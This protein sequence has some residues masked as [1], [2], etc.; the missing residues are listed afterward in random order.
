MANKLF[1]AQLSGVF[2]TDPAVALWTYLKNNWDIATGYTSTPDYGLAGGSITKIKFDTKFG[3]MIGYNFVIVENMPVTIKP[4]DLGAGRFRYTDTKRIQIMTEGTSAK[5][6]KW[7]MER[8]IDS[9]I[10]GNVTGMQ[11]TYGIDEILLSEFVEI[12]VDVTEAEI[13]ERKASRVL[14]ARSRA[15]VTMIYDQYQLVA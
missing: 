15:L 12:P 6:L 2:T 11:A 9:I 3:D 10:N 14:T 1:N 8:H 7:N 13:T 5:N 4:Q